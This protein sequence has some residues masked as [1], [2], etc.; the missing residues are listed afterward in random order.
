MTS[1]IVQ[2]PNSSP[3]LAE[4]RLFPENI[5]AESARYDEHV[6]DVRVIHQ[7]AGKV[8]RRF[9]SGEA[10]LVPPNVKVPA[11]PRII[12]NLHIVCACKQKTATAEGE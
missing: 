4:Y 7:K 12:N 5:V 10:S 2:N 1:K 3:N 8:N 9:S 11:N 6:A